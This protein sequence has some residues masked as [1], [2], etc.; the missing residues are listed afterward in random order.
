MGK[1]TFRYIL[2]GIIVLACISSVYLG[3]QRY[4]IEKS[5]KQVEV[6]MLYDELEYLAKSS[7]KT[8]EEILETFKKLGMTG[9]LYK[10]NSLNNLFIR[11][12]LMDL[13]GNENIG[14]FSGRELI[15]LLKIKNKYDERIDLIIPEYIYLLSDKDT[16][17]RIKDNI[18]VSSSALHVL[19]KDINEVYLLGISPFYVEN[20]IKQ[21]ISVGMG[22]KDKEL[23]DAVE[24]NLNILVQI[25]SWPVSD[26]LSIDKVI[27]NL[28]QQLLPYMD[29]LT[30]IAFNDSVLPGYPTQIQELANEISQF[31]VPVGF[32]ESFIFK[33]LGIKQLGLQE[34]DNGVDLRKRIAR[35]HAASA[36]EMLKLNKNDAV[37]RFLL[38]VKERAARVLLV[39]MFPDKGT[40]IVL[41]KNKDYI[42]SLIKELKDNGFTLGKASTYNNDVTSQS[43]R[44]FLLFIIG[45]GII[46]AGLLLCDILN[47]TLL[48][49][50]L[51]CIVTL[52]WT[53]VFIKTVLIQGNS[54]FFELSVKLMALLAVIIFPT[55]SITVTVK[56]RNLDIYFALLQFLKMSALSLVGAL[57]MVGMLADLRYMLKLDQFIGVKVGLL[58]PILLI[59]LIL[60]IY[61]DRISFTNNL[62]EIF[63]GL[64]KSVNYY[65]LI[66]VGVFAGAAFLFIIRSGNFGVISGFE[67]QFRDL[68]Q[69]ILGV[70]PRTKEFVIGHPFML[71]FLYYGYMKRYLPLMIIGA[72]GQ[73]SMV[74]TFAHIHTPI[75]ISIIRTINGLWLG[76]LIGL[77]L[78]YLCKL[79]NYL[80]ERYLHE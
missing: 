32:V 27:N 29:N 39:R 31:E 19:K 65:T 68:M 15:N 69:N 21:K 62:L 63:K 61:K 40:G 28:N 47:L 8:T 64:K 36:G 2:I 1:K 35:L 18:K 52:G 79:F 46:A 41:E 3:Y 4:I 26:D 57:L 78:L 53:A 80:K 24:C 54:Y 17:H 56:K 43:A 34:A 30:L 58:A 16:Y 42:N 75:V 22:F 48:G 66:L 50:I 51:A 44:Y 76:I 73:V 23:Q 5:S 33:Q 72:I 55:L 12:T 67:N 38:A 59:I 49:L 11:D 45:M 71:L 10:E 6:A 60:Y 70:R 7:G 13:T 37:D 74:N 14:V 9:I 20:I 77:L 25:C